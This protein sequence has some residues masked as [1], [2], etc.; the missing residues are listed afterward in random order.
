MEAILFDP[1]HPDNEAVW[2]AWISLRG[3]LVARLE[4]LGWQSEVHFAVLP[5]GR[6]SFCEKLLL[7]LHKELHQEFGC[8]TSV[9][10]IFRAPEL[11]ERSWTNLD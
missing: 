4:E 9:G 5:N 1:E 3:E 6:M 10:L 8:L 7:S 2:T 11:D